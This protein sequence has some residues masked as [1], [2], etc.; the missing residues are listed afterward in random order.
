[1]HELENLLWTDWPEH[2][3]WDRPP[4]WWPLPLLTVAGLVVGLV[5]R[6]LPGV[7]GHVPALGLHAP[8]TAP[9]ALPGVIIAALVSPTLG[10]TL[11]PEAPLI[12]LGG[13][14]AALFARPARAPTTPQST[15]LLGAAGSAA[16]LSAIFGNRLIGAV[17][18]MEVAG[19]GGSQLFAVMLPALLS[20]GVGSLVFT[21]FGRCTGLSTGSLTL[22]LGVPSGPTFPALFS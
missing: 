16:A 12:A 1:M 19:V 8:G 18:L 13:G 3:G 20:S 2:F 7:G 15:A 22:K 10:A 9:A 4:W 5:V 21:G 6:Y 17:I 14:L 11:G